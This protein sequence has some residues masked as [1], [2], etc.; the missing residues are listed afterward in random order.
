MYD[1]NPDKLAFFG[2]QVQLH[3]LLI[4]CK[5]VSGPDI[6][7]AARLVK[8]SVLHVKLEGYIPTMLIRINLTGM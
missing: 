1:F 7:V 8:S 5:G 2:P 4:G 3:K 6:G